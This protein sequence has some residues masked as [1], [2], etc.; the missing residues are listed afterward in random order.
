[1]SEYFSGIVY[2]FKLYGGDRAVYVVPT[3]GAH[4]TALA[5]E[6]GELKKRGWVT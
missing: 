3:L 6:L 5:H 2:K 4:A 1:V